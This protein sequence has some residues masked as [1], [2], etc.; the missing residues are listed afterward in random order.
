MTSGAERTCT[1]AGPNIV[2]ISPVDRRYRNPVRWPNEL[3]CETLAWRALWI[4]RN[5]VRRAFRE[6]DRSWS[7]PFGRPS[8][9]L[10]THL[11]FGRKEKIICENMTCGRC[12][13]WFTLSFFRQTR[14]TPNN[15]SVMVFV[16]SLTGCYFDERFLQL[17]DGTQY[18][19]NAFDFACASMCRFH[20]AVTER[21]IPWGQMMGQAR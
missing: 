17:I 4:R 13:M 16:F 12:W 5:S 1:H 15:G 9:V 20:G 2:H 11:I 14:T 3:W 18:T 7:T 19:F 8:D 21:E 10:C 6:F